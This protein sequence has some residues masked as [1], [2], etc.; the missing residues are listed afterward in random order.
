MAKNNQW[1]LPDDNNGPGW[2]GYS[3]HSYEALP[4]RTNKLKASE[5]LDFRDQ[6]FNTYFKNNDYLSLIRDTFNLTARKHIEEMTN[7]KLKRKHHYE[8]VAY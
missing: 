3:Q 1:Q 2:I 7:H 8:D 4:L 6:A 5:V